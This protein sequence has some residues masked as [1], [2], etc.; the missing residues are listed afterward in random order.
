MKYYTLQDKNN[1]YNEGK[2]EKAEKRK[3][4]MEQSEVNLNILTLH[5]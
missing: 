5:N 3:H 1:D 4:D 2:T